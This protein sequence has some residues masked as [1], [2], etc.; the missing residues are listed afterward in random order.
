MARSE[1]TTVDYYPYI[2][3][4]GKAMFYIDKKYGNDGYATWHRILRQLAVTSNH[5]INLSREVDLMYL[6]GK[7]NVT[8][9][10]LIQIIVDLCSLEEIDKELWETNRVVWSDKFVEN[11]QD[12]Y[13]KRNNKCITKEELKEFLNYPSIRKQYKSITEASINTH[14]I[15]DNSIVDNKKEDEGKAPLASSSKVEEKRLK[16]SEWLKRDRAILLEIKYKN[17]GLDLAKIQEELEKFDQ[18]HI[19]TYFTGIEH[20]INAWGLWCGKIR[21]KQFDSEH[22]SG[23][24]QKQDL[25]VVYTKPVEDV[26]KKH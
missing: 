12:A 13:K 8:E 2:C 17:Q 24:G 4:E 1:K 20:C 14:T 9:D 3:K 26:S 11:I 5:F 6:A 16:P 21:K 15:V 23:P 19:Q 10:K 7:C 22:K 18:H 25:K